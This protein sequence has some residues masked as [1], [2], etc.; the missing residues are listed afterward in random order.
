MKLK[1]KV[2]IVT[3]A[4]RGIGKAIAEA[5]AKSGAR[6]VINYLSSEKEAS[7][8]VTELKKQNPQVEK[9]KADISKEEEVKELID[10]TVKQFGGIDILVNNAGIVSDKEWNE[11]TVEEWERLM[12]TNLIGAFLT[13]KY[14]SEYLKESKAGRI[15]NISSTNATKAYSPYA[16]DYDATKAGLISLTKD[17]SVALSP[18]VLVN[19]VL[20]GW[21]DTDM[22]KELS[23]DY[24]KEEEEKTFIKRFG[25][26]EEIANV[27]LF[28]ASEQASFVNGSIIDVDG[29]YQ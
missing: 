26:P 12:R 9:F 22:N 21:V 2:V 28:L 25:K 5:F 1:E 10:F 24:I 19:A 27:V 3:G 15:I 18:N 17:L 29:G 14:A 13:S 23:K 16:M 8:L 4:S 11:K 6:V 7:S 20:P